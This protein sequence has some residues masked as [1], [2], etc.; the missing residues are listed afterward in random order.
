MPG[1]DDV[2]PVSTDPLGPEPEAQPDRH[3]QPVDHEQPPRLPFPVVGVGA[4]AGGLEAFTAFLTAVRPASG[5]AYVFVQHLPPERESM[6]AEILR[7]GRAC[8]C[9]RSRTGWR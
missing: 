2:Q 3:A 4:S 8:A 5:M 6:M 9:S 7:S 1:D